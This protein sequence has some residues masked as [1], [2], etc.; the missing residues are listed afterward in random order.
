M[1]VKF[2][3]ENSEVPLPEYTPASAAG[4]D[5]AAFENT[6]IPPKQMARIRTGLYVDV[7]EGYFLALLPR[8]STPARTGLVFP[9]SVGVIDPTY[10]GPEDEIQLLV[11]NTLDKE[12]LVKKGERIAQGL[13]IPAPKV[14]WEEADKLSDESRGG[15][16]S[17]GK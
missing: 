14:E 15:F 10:S 16:G 4:F 8:S 7:P 5:V 6:A 1:K 2:R 3:R 12:C 11:Y 13:I 17:T 9:H